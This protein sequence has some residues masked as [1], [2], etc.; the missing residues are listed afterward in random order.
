[1]YVN[2]DRAMPEKNLVKCVKDITQSYGLSHE[3]AQVADD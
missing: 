1:M 3:D 2:G